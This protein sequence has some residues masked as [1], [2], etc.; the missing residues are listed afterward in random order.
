MTRSS[1]DDSY[2]LPNFA[3][4]GVMPRSDLE[5][6]IPPTLPDLPSAPEP[7][8]F[9]VPWWMAPPMSPTSPRT[10][11]Q[12]YD[13][14]SGLPWWVTPP[15][16][17]K[18]PSPSKPTSPLLPQ[19][20]SSF[21]PSGDIAPAESV[22]GLVDLLRQLTRQREPQSSADFLK[23]AHASQTAS[24]IQSPSLQ[25]V[26]RLSGEGDRYEP[27]SAGLASVLSPSTATVSNKR[28]IAALPPPIGLISGEPMEH[29][30]VPIF[31]TRQ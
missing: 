17:P 20:P 3:I 1:E 24:A 7:P 9:W 2:R 25:T 13:L 15:A 19:G 30:M 28:K 21:N 27:R 18:S 8:S 11:P 22:D 12:P 31:D 5:K 14:P 10:A 4:D 29:W 26:R 16:A 23:Q 6:W